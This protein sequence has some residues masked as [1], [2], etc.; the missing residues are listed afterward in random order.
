MPHCHDGG[1]CRRSTHAWLA[2]CFIASTLLGCLAETRKLDVFYMRCLR[3]IA[4]IQHSFY[5][6]VSNQ[7]V[8]EIMGCKPLSVN[9]KRQQLLYIANLARREHGN[10]LRNCIF[11]PNSF[12]LKQHVG[13]RRRG[14]PRITW[15]GAVFDMAVSIAGSEESLAQFWANTP[16]A[17]SRWTQAVDIYCSNC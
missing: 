1:N 9:L 12:T 4:G 7:R 10:V 17:R 16:D 14:R 8:L 15:A 6:R 3:T 2:S 13:P 11:E 5:S